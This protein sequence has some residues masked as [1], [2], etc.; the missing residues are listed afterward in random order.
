[1]ASYTTPEDSI[2]PGASQVMGWYPILKAE[3]V[4][5]R[6]LLDLPSHHRVTS[7]TG[8]ATGSESRAKPPIHRLLQQPRAF[9]GQACQRLDGWTWSRNPDPAAL[10]EPTTGFAVRRPGS[11]VSFVCRG[12]WSRANLRPRGGLTEIST[13]GACSAAPTG[14]AAAIFQARLRRRFSQL[15][16]RDC[17]ASWTPRYHNH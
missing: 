12:W 4:E 8:P 13:A 17:P 6:R 5:Q 15:D 1:M 3:L 9:G 14:F 7:S 11:P 16:G 2:R 10:A